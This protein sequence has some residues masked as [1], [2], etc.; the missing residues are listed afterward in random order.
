MNISPEEMAGASAEVEGLSPY[1][2][3]LASTTQ[4]AALRAGEGL[5]KPQLASLLDAVVAEWVQEIRRVAEQADTLSKVL[6]DSGAEFQRTDV[7]SAR[8]FTA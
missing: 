2:L 7:H 5:A 1:I 8:R 6:T 3:E 4:Q